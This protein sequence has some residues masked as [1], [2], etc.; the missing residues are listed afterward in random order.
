MTLASPASGRAESPPV[1][2][3]PE[4]PKALSLED[5][6]AG[7]FQFAGGDKDRA[8]RVLAI[9]RSVAPLIFLIRGIARDKLDDKT[10]IAA[11]VSFRFENGKIRCGIPGAPDA[12]SPADGRSVNYT[13]FGDT[14]KLSQRVDGGAT[15][16]RSRPRMERERTS[17][18]RAKTAGGT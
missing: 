8:A 3:A 11:V 16:R 1:Q 5:R 15:S 9:E 17:M 4:S 18:S 2:P 12:V 13:A 14:L 10:K 6:V 7:D